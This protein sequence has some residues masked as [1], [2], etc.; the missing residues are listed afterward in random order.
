MNGMKSGM[1]SS[2]ANAYKIVPAST[3]LSVLDTR[4]SSISLYRS[5]RRFGKNMSRPFMRDRF[6]SRSSPEDFTRSD[7][8]IHSTKKIA[9]YIQLR[10]HFNHKET[11]TQRIFVLFVV[12]LI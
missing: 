7:I 6:S 9:A 2:G 5:L 4:G 10:H 12:F 8:F 3:A 11:K 1:K